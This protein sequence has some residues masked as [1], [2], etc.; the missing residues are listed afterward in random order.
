ML[1]V[2]GGHSRNIGKTS[3]VAGLIRKLRDRKWTALKVT[4]Y[5][6]GVCSHHGEACGC[7]TEPEHPFALSEEYEPS[8]TDSGRFLAAGAERSFWLRTPMG[9]LAR[10]KNTLDKI[11][12][13]GGNVI[14]E[15]NSVVEFV[16]PDLFLM[17]LDFSCGDFKPSS[18][19]FMDRADAFVV[20]DRGIA[21]PMWEEVA[22]GLW[23]HKPQ[24]LV[25]PPLYVTAAVSEFVRSRLSPR[26]SR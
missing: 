22:R 20:I 6:H 24:F 13:S 12:R 3:V 9:E 21:V 11:T 18:L 7:E 14:I 26:A 8:R 15:S 23:D 4:Q 10:A 2:V 5:G 19:R 16:Q 25:K 1:V 17:V